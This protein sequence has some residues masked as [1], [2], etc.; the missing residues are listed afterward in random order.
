MQRAEHGGVE[1]YFDWSFYSQGTRGVGDET[2]ARSVGDATS[3][4]AEALKFFG[5]R[6]LAESPA[7]AWDKGA[8]L[9]TLVAQQHSLLILD[10]LEPLQHP[11]GPQVGEL[12]DDGL[13]ALFFGLQTADRG[14]CVVTTRERLR[15]LDATDGCSTSSRKL[16]HLSD[17]AGAAVLRGHGVTGPM[18]EL[19]QVSREVR[20][21]ALTLSLMGQ[22]LKLAFE[23]PDIA[24]RDCF[25]FQEADKEVQNGHAF[26]VFAAYEEWLLRVGWDSVPTKSVVTPVTPAPSPLDRATPMDEPSAN[27]KTK[28]KADGMESHPTGERLVAILRL[29]GLF[30]RPATPDCVAALCAEPLPG[31]NEPLLNLSNKEWTI[32]VNRLKEL[33]LIEPLPWQPVSTVMGYGKDAARGVFGTWE[34]IGEPQ[35]HAVPA[36]RVPLRMSLDAHPVLR[37]YFAERLRSEPVVAFRSAKERLG[38]KP[39]TADSPSDAAESGRSFAERKATTNTFQLAHARLFEHLRQSVPYWP[40]GRE[41]LLPLYQAVAHGCLAG[42]FQEACDDVSRNRILRGTAGTHAFY[43]RNK[44]GLLSLD[45]AAVACFFV[46][47]WS[48]LAESLAPGAQAWLL[49]DAAYS[50]RA[51]NRLTEARDAFRAALG[52]AVAEENW[53][54]A[55]IR[56]SNLSELELTLGE[57]AAAEATAAQSVTFADRSGDW[58]QKMR[59]RATHADALHQ[60]GRRAESCS[61]F[62]EAEALQFKSQPDYPQ[63]YSLPGYRYCDLL[64]AACERAAWQSGHH[65]PRDEPSTRDLDASLR[66]VSSNGTAET[67][68]PSTSDGTQ[69]ADSAKAHHVERDGYIEILDAVERRATQTLEWAIQNRLSLLTIALDHLTLGR[70]LLLRAVL[71]GAAT[72]ERLGPARDALATALH[73]LRQ[74]NFS[75]MLPHAL[76]PSA[77]CHVLLGERDSAEQ[78]LNEAF[79]LATRCGN[80]STNDFQ[81]GMRLHLIDTLL[82]RACLFGCRLGLCPDLVRWDSSHDGSVSAQPRPSKKRATFHSEDN[83]E[84]GRDGIPTYNYPWQDSSPAA[85]LTLAAHLIKVTGYHRRDEELADA[86]AALGQSA[87]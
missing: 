44:L 76:L 82:H 10:G 27:Q 77:W 15:D 83:D 33:D 38:A 31:L 4:L 39:S 36:V 65:A 46:A 66:V 8:R 14:L 51:L 45:L 79:Q 40:E 26:R 16:D 23:K 35:P 34:D 52:L 61:L 62:A 24:Q 58:S 28:A 6:E 69:G 5:D 73:T 1:R 59:R 80:S 43:S 20:G 72:A 86:Q 78:R 57:V 3:F 67:F 55:A 32:A 63:L 68:L 7:P 50:L 17:D 22:F 12:L 70:V 54:A 37:E 75:Y 47:P 84:E 18:E 11:P 64:L 42:R 25:Q 2:A 13:K 87:E 60:A 9:A 29:L 41:G 48:R 74:A 71:T 85:D 56:A 53:K 30:D 21:H 49:S 81:G 19:R